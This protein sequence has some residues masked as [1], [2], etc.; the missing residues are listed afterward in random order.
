MQNQHA[1]REKLG[2][3]VLLVIFPSASRNPHKQKP[4]VEPCLGWEE[5]DVVGDMDFS[6]NMDQKMWKESWS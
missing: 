3:I 1:F 5:E 6:W 4:T 2:R